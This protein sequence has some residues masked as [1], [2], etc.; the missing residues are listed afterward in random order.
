MKSEK[1]TRWMA[2][3]FLVMALPFT[4]VFAKAES[5][6]EE[7]AYEI[8]LEAYVYLH[9]IITMDVT[10]RVI[11][12]VPVGAKPGAGPK[13]MFQH[14]R[15]FPPADMREV[16]RPN[17]DTLYSTAWLDLTKEPMV[18]SMPDTKGRYYILPVYDMW[19][20]VFVAAGKR[21]SGTK[22]GN[23]ALYYKGFSGKLPEGMTAVESPTPYVWIINRIQTNGPKDYAFVNGLQDGFK[24]TPL[25]VY[26][27]GKKVEKPFK[28]DPS[29]DM[30]T[31][32]FDQVTKMEPGQYFSYGAELMKLHPPHMTDYA[33]VERMK[34][35]GIVAGESFDFDKASPTVKKAL[36]RAGV[37]GLAL[38]KKLIPSLAPV[39]NGW[40][41]ATST[42]GVYGNDYMKRA[43]ITLVGLGAIPPADAI[44]PMA[45]AD[46]DGEP[47]VGTKNYVLHFD[48]DEVPPVEA[49]W[50]ITM[51]DE[52]G[53]QVANS[54]NR[55]A[56]G[57][58]DDLKYNN[59]GSLDIYI[60]P[61]S[62]GKSK[63]TNWL[64]SPDHGTLGVTMRLYAPKPEALDGMWVPP[65]IKKAK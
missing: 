15:A 29:V 35:I 33:V 16:V 25:S 8:A 36:E 64:P 41:M 19:T 62:P 11:T 18:I 57:D 39:R 4:S 58:R 21:T 28:V 46:A 22:A 63:E 44:Y 59:D 7:E 3:A 60:Q 50:S 14:L 13:N 34:R 24:I 51:Y 53:F 49:F 23:I 5:I 45:I 56:I 9:P 32:P 37:D 61:K 55:F 38:M 26:N 2:A 43:V 17:F 20:D 54:L 47:L 52:E 6:S 10:R 65:A 40:T 12:N 48:K 1:L 42:M 27:G 31:S 30:K